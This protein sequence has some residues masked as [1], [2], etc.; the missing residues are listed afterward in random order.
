M[1]TAVIIGPETNLFLLGKLFPAKTPKVD[2][3]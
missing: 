2:E 1:Q 3:L